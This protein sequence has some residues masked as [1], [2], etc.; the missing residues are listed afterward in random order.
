V[1][2]FCGVASAS[3]RASTGSPPSIP[4]LTGEESVTLDPLEM[5]ARLRQPHARGAGAAAGRDRGEAGI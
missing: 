1:A 3:S 5:L 2:S 4:P